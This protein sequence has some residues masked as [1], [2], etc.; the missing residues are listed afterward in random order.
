[1]NYRKKRKPGEPVTRL[2]PLGWTWIG[3]ING[4]L[5]RSVQNNFIRIYN[6]KQVELQQINSAL[7]KFSA[8]E[9]VAD[10]ARRIMNKDNKDTLYLISKF[11]KV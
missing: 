4:L 7:T 6:T 1:M 5:E 9:S 2:T 11:F 3:H 8:I 10:N